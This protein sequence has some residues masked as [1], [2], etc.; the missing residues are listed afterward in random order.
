M[1]DKVFWCFLPCLLVWK[2]KT[3]AV[4]REC[5]GVSVAAA[6]LRPQVLRCLAFWQLPVPPKQQGFHEL[7]L[8]DQQTG[9]PLTCSPGPDVQ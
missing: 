3:D 8:R 9:L 7:A 1:L 2:E 4:L 5:G 6:A